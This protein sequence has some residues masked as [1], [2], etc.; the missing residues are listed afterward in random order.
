MI[1]RELEMGEK[2]P[3]ELLLLADPSKKIV[4]EYVNRGDCFI[5]ECGNQVVGIYVLLPTRPKTV[6]LVNVAVAVEHQGMGLG[7]S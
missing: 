6:E 3:Y 5:A 1:I 7:N 2:I 4:E